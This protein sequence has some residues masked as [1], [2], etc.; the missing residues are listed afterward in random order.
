MGA[1]STAQSQN[2][3]AC[4]KLLLWKV[5]ALL[6]SIWTAIALPPYFFFHL[7]LCNAPWQTKYGSSS[8]LGI[9]CRSVR[10]CCNGV[11]RLGFNDALKNARSIGQL[12]FF[13]RVFGFWTGRGVIINVFS[14]YFL[15]TRQ[16]LFRSL[17]FL[18]RA[19]SRECRFNYV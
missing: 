15:K 10:C 7:E 11:L 12:E 4:P 19:N 2:G 5:Y 14:F 13:T 9:N 16:Q 3:T 6:R 1:F 17:I 8:A 18:Q